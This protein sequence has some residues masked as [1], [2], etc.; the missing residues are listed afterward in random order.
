MA[1]TIFGYFFKG[2]GGILLVG[3]ILVFIAWKPLG[4]PNPAIANLVSFSLFILQD[5]IVTHLQL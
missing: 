3:A 2:F 4:E 5:A 1:L